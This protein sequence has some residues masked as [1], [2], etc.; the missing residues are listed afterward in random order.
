MVFIEIVSEIFLIGFLSVGDMDIDKLDDL[1]YAVFADEMILRQSGP[2][3]DTRYEFGMALSSNKFYEMIDRLKDPHLSD[4]H[5]MGVIGDIDTSFNLIANLKP[6]KAFLFDNDL[7]KVQYLGLRLHFLKQSA[8]VE[9]NY[10]KMLRIPPGDETAEL[11]RGSDSVDQL[12][13]RIGGLTLD[14]EAIARHGENLMQNMGYTRGAADV[15]EVFLDTD[16]R[17]RAAIEM[18]RNRERLRKSVKEGYNWFE[19]EMMR[20]LRE[21]AFGHNIKG[22]HADFYGRFSNA[23]TM[24][25]REYGIKNLVV[26][27]SRLPEIERQ[28]ANPNFRSMSD[29][30]RGLPDEVDQLFVITK[31]RLDPHFNIWMPYMQK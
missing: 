5:L 26:Y 3:D 23:A 1:S 6:K 30:F 7:Q 24:L 22:F 20:Y 25:V 18:V 9:E 21:F 13:M 2:L 14:P 16:F 31:N 15:E 29:A 27:A 19:K 12:V 11:L 28:K 17:K 10:L 4:C 8:S